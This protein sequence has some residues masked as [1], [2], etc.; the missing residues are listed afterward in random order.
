MGICFL[1]PKDLSVVF[2]NG[3]S[4]LLHVVKTARTIEARAYWLRLCKLQ[5][6]LFVFKK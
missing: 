4:E 1:A 6:V 3:Q 2:L 5:T